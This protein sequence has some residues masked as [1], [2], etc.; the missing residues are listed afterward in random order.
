MWAS[1]NTDVV[2]RLIYRAG[3]AHTGAKVSDNKVDTPGSARSKHETA[4]RVDIV[5]WVSGAICVRIQCLLQLW[6]HAQE[7]ACLRV[8]VAPDYEV[9]RDA[10]RTVRHRRRPGQMSANLDAEVCA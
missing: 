2:V 7:L 10:V 9:N 3:E 8:V 5:H 6:V 4:G 1:N